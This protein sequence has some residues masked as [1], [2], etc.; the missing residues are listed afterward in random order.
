MAG[1]SYE[2]YKILLYGDE[3]F[4]IT[5][6]DFDISK[7]IVF[8]YNFQEAI[9]FEKES[10][11]DPLSNKETCQVYGGKIQ[12]IWITAYAERGTAAGSYEGKVLI[13]KAAEDWRQD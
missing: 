1:N 9:A 3:D 10:F 6:V 2:S 5:G 8:R 13:T 4:E 7:D 12:S 11:Q